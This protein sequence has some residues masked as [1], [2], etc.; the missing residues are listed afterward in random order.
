[1][2]VSLCGEV[3]RNLANAFLI[4]PILDWYFCHV[5]WGALWALF[6]QER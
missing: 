3:F 5:F 2:A 6:G 1:M 4:Y